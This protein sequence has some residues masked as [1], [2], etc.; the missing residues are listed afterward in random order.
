MALIDEILWARNALAANLDNS[1]DQVFVVII[2]SVGIQFEYTEHN[3]LIA[4]LPSGVSSPPINIRSGFK[5]SS[6]AVPSAKNSGFDSTSNLMPGLVLAF[7]ILLILSAART[8]TVLFSTTILLLTE[9]LAISLATC[10]RFCKSAAFPLP[11]PNVFVGVLTEMKTISALFY[12]ILD[13]VRKEKVLSATFLHN[14]VEFWLKKSPMMWW[15]MVG[16]L[17]LHQAWPR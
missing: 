16:S 12:L 2:F 15:L 4:L 13:V 17:Q 9:K 5:R 1:E 6:I 8:G 7:N 14:F 3:S 10:S 11:K